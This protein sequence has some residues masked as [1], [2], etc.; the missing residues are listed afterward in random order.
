ME[1]ESTDHYTLSS[2]GYFSPP[3]VDEFGK[4]EM[5]GIDM[6]NLFQRQNS[7]QQLENSPG[8]RQMD[9]LSD[10]NSSTNYSSKYSPEHLDTLD[11]QGS[12]DRRGDDEVLRHSKLPPILRKGIQKYY[13]PIVDNA[14]VYK[15]E[16]N[17]SEYKKAR[18]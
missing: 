13:E 1:Y 9:V 3:F 5:G 7:T 15:Y 12:M 14:V 17:P 16:D 2:P 6:H 8:H 4:N 11:N 18:K 10:S